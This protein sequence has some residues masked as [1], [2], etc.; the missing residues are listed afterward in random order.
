MTMIGAAIRALW[1]F[2]QDLKIKQKLVLIFFFLMIVPLASFTLLAYKQASQVIEDNTIYSARQSLEQAASSIASKINS[3]SLISDYIILDEEATRVFGRMGAPSYGVPMQVKDSAYLLR[4]FHYLL[5]NQD[6]FLIRLFVP[7][8][9]VYSGDGQSIYSM[10]GIRQEPWYDQLASSSV[11]TLLSPTTTHY[12]DTSGSMIENDV[13]STIRFVKNPNDFSMNMAVLSVDILQSDVQEL[14]TKAARMTNTGMMYMA[15]SDGVVLSTATSEQTDDWRVTDFTIEQWKRTS[16]QGKQA[17]VGYQAID[18]TDWTLVSVVPL[19]DI[20]TASSHQRNVWILIMLAMAVIAFLLAYISSVSSTKRIY[21]LIFKM[22]QVQE[23]HLSVIKQNFGRD[24]IG[25]LAENYNFMIKR[26]EI[27]IEEQFK[28]G[29]ERKNTELKLVQAEL[30]ALQSQINPHFLYNTLDLINWMA[31]KHD[32]PEIESLIGSMSNFYKLSLRKGRAIV[33]IGDEMLHLQTY[34][35]IQNHRFENSITLIWNIDEE[36]MPYEIPKITLQPLVEN[37]IVHGIQMKPDKIG[38]I[39]ISGGLKDG[40]IT[41]RIQDDGIGMSAKD[42]AS[43]PQQHSKDEWH[44]YGVYN[45]HERIKLYF[46]AQYGLSFASI[47][48]AGTTVEIRFPPVLDR[49][50]E[51]EGGF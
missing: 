21:R 36:V 10:K 46:G 17:I 7:D 1:S 35:E 44:G 51:N 43:M 31:I 8:E 14:M 2:I 12:T 3:A 19:D 6:I 4:L 18:N 37:S 25:E 40:V 13:L 49:Q 29:Q 5:R 23:G 41:L 24:E 50:N 48:G 28:T 9:L 15:S 20:L 33:T 38:T 30:K 32:V 26:I 27:L 39:A 42:L 34:I 47:P 16:V 45:I 22:R 11:T